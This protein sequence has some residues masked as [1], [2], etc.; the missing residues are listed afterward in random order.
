MENRQHQPMA[1]VANI[2][3]SWLAAKSAM[4]C[5]DHMLHGL[6]EIVECAHNALTGGDLLLVIGTSA[7]VQILQSVL[8]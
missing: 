2:Q 4:D 5:I 6:E 7:V 8:N 1:K 3:C